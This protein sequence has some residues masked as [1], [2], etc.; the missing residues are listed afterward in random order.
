MKNERDLNQ[1]PLV[2]GNLK[3]PWWV[4]APLLLSLWPVWVYALGPNPTPSWMHTTSKL[5]VICPFAL[6]ASFFIF[7]TFRKRSDRDGFLNELNF[8][9]ASSETKRAIS[10]FYFDTNFPTILPNS[11]S[12]KRS[13][14]GEHNNS[15]YEIHEF[16]HVSHPS[17]TNYTIATIRVCPAPGPVVIRMAIPSIARFYHIHR[18]KIGSAW[19]QQHWITHGDFTTAEFWITNEFE[20]EFHDDI[21]PK[22]ILCFW[23]GNRLGFG[24]IGTPTESGVRYCLEK[25]HSLASIS[26]IK[27]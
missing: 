16:R 22:G 4:I 3:V 5:S 15:A 2:V 9:P 19:F 8:E 26:G 21:K 18:L 24:F 11:A 27:E 25:A 12:L 23:C 13:F 1:E 20:S 17:I 14:S 7:I 10:S 6:L